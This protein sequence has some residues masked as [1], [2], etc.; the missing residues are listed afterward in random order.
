MDAKTYRGL[1]IVDFG[2]P[3][4]PVTL[5]CRI[6]KKVVTFTRDMST[7]EIFFGDPPDGLVERAIS[8]DGNTIAGQASQEDVGGSFVWRWT[9]TRQ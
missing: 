8:A 9:L 4:L 7:P 6:D 1:G 3:P 2:R 5:T